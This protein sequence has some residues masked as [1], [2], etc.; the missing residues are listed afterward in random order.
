ME[1]GVVMAKMDL[2]GESKGLKESVILTSVIM[3]SIITISGLVMTVLYGVYAHKTNILGQGDQGVVTQKMMMGSF[4]SLALGW[5]AYF[6]AIRRVDT[7]VGQTLLKDY[8]GENWAYDCQDNS[9]NSHYLLGLNG[10]TYSQLSAVER[11]ALTTAVALDV[12]YPSWVLSDTDLK[13]VAM[14]KNKQDIKTILE[15]STMPINAKKIQL[16][17]GVE[18]KI[19]KKAN[20]VI[21]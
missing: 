19:G 10:K 20:Q 16:M 4:A 11:Q 18:R 7:R 5:A 8:L 2:E 6:I 15:K 21:L 13:M 9:V 17:N 1:L 14:A 12:Y 3:S